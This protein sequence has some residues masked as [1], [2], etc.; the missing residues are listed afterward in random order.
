MKAIDVLKWICDASI[1]GELLNIVDVPEEGNEEWE[2]NKEW[3]Y[4]TFG[5]CP[6]HAISS[7]RYL[8]YY[9][10]SGIDAGIPNSRGQWEDTDAEIEIPT[11]G[12]FDYIYL[13]KL[14]D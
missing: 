9:Q 4:N 6:P 13:Y 1:E 11:E 14:E 10:S 7:G 3:W 12:G 2:Q 8:Y 5:N